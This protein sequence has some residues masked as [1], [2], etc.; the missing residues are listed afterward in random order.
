MNEKMYKLENVTAIVFNRE[1]KE[2]HVNYKCE[3]VV[4]YD[5]SLPVFTGNMSASG[6]MNKSRV[7]SQTTPTTRTHTSTAN[8]IVSERVAKAMGRAFRNA[9]R[10]GLVENL[11]HELVMN[12]SGEVS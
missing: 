6:K 9:G 8:A 1:T 7:L 2:Y 3:D 5:I 10:V 11:G 12:I 4:E